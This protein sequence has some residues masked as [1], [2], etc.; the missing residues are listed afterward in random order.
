MVSNGAAFEKAYAA[1]KQSKR[2]KIRERRNQSAELTRAN[3]A[4]LHSHV[5]PAAV[6]SQSWLPNT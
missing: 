3:R 6:Y 4:A 5:L 2:S 1:H